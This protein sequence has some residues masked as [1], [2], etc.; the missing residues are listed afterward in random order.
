MLDAFVGSQSALRLRERQVANKGGAD[1]FI[2]RFRAVGSNGQGAAARE[3][4]AL[5]KKGGR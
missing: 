3:L 4:R 2:R 5:D 1:E